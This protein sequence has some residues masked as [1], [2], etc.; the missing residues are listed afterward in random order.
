MRYS[1]ILASSLL[2][3]L[4][5]LARSEG[6]PGQTISPEN[7]EEMMR[8]V[9]DRRF[10]QEKFVRGLKPTAS[11]KLKLVSEGLVDQVNYIY[12]WGLARS[13]D[14]TVEQVSDIMYEIVLSFHYSEAV[15]LSSV[16]VGAPLLKDLR[17]RNCVGE[18]NKKF[19][20]AIPSTGG[21]SIKE[22]EHLLYDIL[23]QRGFNSDHLLSEVCHDSGDNPSNPRSE[24]KAESSA[25][26]TT[27]R[28]VPKQGATGDN[29]QL[30]MVIGGLIVLGLIAITGLRLLL[31]IKRVQR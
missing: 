13:G 22:A 16:R 23:G 8:I 9:Q 6:A 17:A 24:A 5:L 29:R 7:R 25:S 11:L 14:F 1:E 28:D 19:R 15:F 18:F 3:L 27:E 31:E 2:V 12:G 4:A 10:S 21:L 26:P 30:L 20:A